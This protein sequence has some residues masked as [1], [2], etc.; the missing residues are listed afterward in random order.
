MVVEINKDNFEKEVKNS[1]IPVL[2]DFWA[3]WCGPCKMMAPVFDKVSTEFEGKL[4]FAKL[5]V[6]ENK[7][8]AAQYNIRGIPCLILTKEGKE[9]DRI[10]GFNPEDVLKQKIAEILSKA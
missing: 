9:V 3:T 8:I 4:K 7:E 5:N 10:T 1:E 6:D 2:I